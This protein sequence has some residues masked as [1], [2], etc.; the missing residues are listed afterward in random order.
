MLAQLERS[1]GRRS[2]VVVV[3]AVEVDYSRGDDDVESGP[4]P[5]YSSDGLGG[6]GIKGRRRYTGFHAAV[7][8][9]D[10]VVT[11]GKRDRAASAAPRF[12][13]FKGPGTGGTGST[14]TFLKDQIVA[15]F[16]VSDNKLAL[17]LFGNKN[18]LQKEKLRQR[19]AGNW[20][21]HPCSNFR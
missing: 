5:N 1:E 9:P 3:K 15:F 21:I 14:G 7:N 11:A 8:P 16:Q 4:P 6:H 13:A 17:K 12:D 19:A 2:T 20:V 18:A 10:S